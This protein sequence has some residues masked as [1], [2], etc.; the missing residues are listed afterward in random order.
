MSN[1]TISCPHDCPACTAPKYYLDEWKSSGK[2]IK[3]GGVR[4]AAKNIIACNECWNLLDIHER[5]EL[6]KLALS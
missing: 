6:C 3:C 1:H 4:V 5:H 2:C